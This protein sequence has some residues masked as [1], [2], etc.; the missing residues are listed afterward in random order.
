MKIQLKTVK[1]LFPN[2]SRRG[3]G[4]QRR[5]GKK[6]KENFHLLILILIKT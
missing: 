4:T 1:V 5:R 3:A 2:S 6:G